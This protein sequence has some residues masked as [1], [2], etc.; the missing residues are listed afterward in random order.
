MVAKARS[1]HPTQPVI[2]I[3]SGRS[4]ISNGPT[5]S[6]NLAGRNWCPVCISFG[7]EICFV[8]S[9]VVRHIDHD[10]DG[11]RITHENRRAAPVDEPPVFASSA[12]SARRRHRHD[13]RVACSRPPSPGDYYVDV[14]AQ[15][16][17]AHPP[18]P[19]A[20]VPRRG[21]AVANGPTLR[22]RLSRTN[23]CP[24]YDRLAYKC[25]SVSQGSRHID[26]HPD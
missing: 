4:T 12:A 15:I 9:G 3:P 6:E 7:N 22:E 5:L 20:I 8:G 17:T 24:V 23:L 13:E 1:T 19:I 11:A 16:R 10:P 25:R 18:Q 21:A 2:R 14:I 26:A